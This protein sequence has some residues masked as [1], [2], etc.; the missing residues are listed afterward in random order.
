MSER[1]ILKINSYIGARIG[2]AIKSCGKKQVEVAR[3]LGMPESGLSAIING[4]KTTSLDKIERIANELGVPPAAFFPDY[5]IP[6]EAT[7]T[8]ILIDS[9]YRDLKQLD[10]EYLDTLKLISEAMRKR[11]EKGK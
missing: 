4:K 6:K 3:A 8:D 1:K 10:P 11:L 2:D 7:E 9:I 5:T